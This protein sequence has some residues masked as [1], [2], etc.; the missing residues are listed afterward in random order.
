MAV[1]DE[2]LVRLG[3][4]MSEAQ[5]EVDEGA[6]GIEGRLNGL[7][8]VGTAAAAGLGGAFVT[9][10]E[11]AM[12]ISSAITTLEQGFGLTKEEADRAGHLSGE[13]FAA[14][15]GESVGG[16][17]DAMG[18]VIGA[19]GKV[20]DFT[21]AELKDMTKSAT[22][23]E[24][25]FGMDI[26]E[27]ANAAGALIKQGLVEDA[28]EAFDVLTK[29]AQTLPA[30][31]AAD[32]PAIVT[33]YGQHFKRIGLDAKTS[34]GMMSQFVQAGG[35]DIDQAADVL[36]E[37][38]RITSEE[39]KR[40]SD[41]FKALGLD[42]KSML[43][44]IG[45]G[46][47]P[48]ADALTKT[49]DAL[50]GVKDPAKRAQLEVALFGD[51]AG[52][53]ADALLAMNPQ[54]AAAASGMDDA[55]GAAKRVTDGMAAS[56]AQQWDSIMRTVTTTLGMAL[57]PVLNAVS[58]LFAKQPGL[59]KALVPIVLSLAAGLAIAAAAQWAMNSAMLANPITWI[60]VAIV[61]MV[62]A[63]VYI[64]TQT[65]A[66]Q[67]AWEVA[68][69]AIKVAAKAVSDWWTGTV[70]PALQAGWNAVKNTVSA[71]A[72]WFTGT[73]KPQL[74]AVWNAIAG[75]ASGMWAK[76]KGYWNSMVSFITGI[77]GRISSAVRGMWDGIPRAFRGAINNIISSWN[78]LSFSIGGGS[79]MGV[80]IPRL[81][82]G[83][84]DIPYLADGGITTGPT[85]AMI[86][87]GSEREAVLPLSRLEQLL[88]QPYAAAS[89]GK[90]Q[91]AGPLAMELR[92]GPRLFREFFQ[93]SVRI[94]AGG[95][96]VKFVEG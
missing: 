74:S 69:G 82:L 7:A 81:T 63:I 96:I 84:P 19:M 48:A 50:R 36:H 76:V 45:K 18:A 55:A 30:S 24:T 73:L 64:A 34:F 78:G 94:T 47:K 68:W 38:A 91:P 83:T 42:S 1:L 88:S 72:N 66:F 26:P 10:L 89:T 16:V 54:T 35:R 4:D 56:P 29:A 5:G 65:Q 58:G 85:L 60:I 39:T 57:L 12:D 3:V 59:V 49:L 90:V 23:L 80:D 52:E 79:F 21:D 43:A 13:V 86:G 20:G 75:G 37:F 53:A 9:G 77:P 11:S 87:E 27:A 22:A 95:D 70:V 14:G 28:T 62:A 8:T 67:K 2:V 31:M 46:G 41:G 93:E 15:F 44:D 61:A 33:E 25:K 17:A 40:A 6:A 71:V 92:G 32:I 51:M